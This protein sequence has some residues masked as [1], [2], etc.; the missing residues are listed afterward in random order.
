M[1]DYTE[2]G[3]VIS[4][5]SLSFAILK[6]NFKK[7]ANNKDCPHNFV[8]KEDCHTAMESINQRINDLDK[9]ITQ[10]LEDIKDLIKNK[11]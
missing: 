9:H 2:V 4:L 8:K 3:I 11:K 10:R 1:I 6:M 7:N 5:A